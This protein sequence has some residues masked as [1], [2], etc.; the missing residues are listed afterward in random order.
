MSLPLRATRERT[1][2]DPQRT[3]SQSGARAQARAVLWSSKGS[4]RHGEVTAMS[5]QKA[6]PKNTRGT[7]RATQA[8]A[9]VAGAAACLAIGWAVGAR[10]AGTHATASRT[11]TAPT[12]TQPTYAMIPGGDDDE[13]PGVQWG[14]VP[15]TGLTPAQPGTG[16]VPP[17]TGTGGSAVAATSVTTKAVAPMTAVVGSTTSTGTTRVGP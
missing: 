2:P 10:S 14:T 12:L 9:G 7:R 15:V 1:D 6:T 4:I 16:I 5:E 13:D 8:V 3:P 11:A 17:S